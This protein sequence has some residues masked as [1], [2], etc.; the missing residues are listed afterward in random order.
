MFVCPC[1][2]VCECMRMCMPL[3]SVHIHVCDWVRCS[4]ILI[5]K[6]SLMTTP[7]IMFTTQE[8]K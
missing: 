4:I 6:V 8:E 7:Q 3:A 5:S 2:S 1:V